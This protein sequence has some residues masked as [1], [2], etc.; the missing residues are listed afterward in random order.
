MDIKKFKVG[1]GYDTR[2]ICD[3]DC[4]IKVIVAK[5]TKCFLTTTEG[6]RLKINVYD[7]AEYVS[8]WGVY[9]MSPIVRAN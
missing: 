5:R 6:K 4:V 7:G 8:P 3:N 9:S 1:Y 2:S